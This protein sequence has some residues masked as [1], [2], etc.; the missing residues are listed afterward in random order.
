MGG[1]RII[2]RINNL[3]NMQ[4]WKSLCIYKCKLNKLIWDEY[5]YRAFVLL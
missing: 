1:E 5:T 4:S 2:K 3:K